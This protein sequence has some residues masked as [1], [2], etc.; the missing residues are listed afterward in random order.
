MRLPRV[1]FTVR[2]M[3]IAV[4]VVAIALGIAFGVARL[5][6]RRD[7]Y[8][9]KTASF[10]SLESFEIR[11][12]KSDLDY[13][14]WARSMAE[15]ERLFLKRMPTEPGGL[16]PEEMRAASAALFAELA[17]G[18]TQEAATSLQKAELGA[19]RAHYFGRL[20]RKYERAAF[21][22]WLPVVPDPPEP[23]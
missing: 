9:I 7:A 23:R 19:R 10:A 17:D 12:R 1:R 14:Q 16:V 22:P 6:R 20:K 11:F 8:L 3:M 21:Y 18:H 5:K 15:K 4:A 2:R 13:A